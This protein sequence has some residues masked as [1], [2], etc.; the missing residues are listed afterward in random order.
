MNNACIHFYKLIRNFL[1]N[2]LTIFKN[3]NFK[4]TNF[5]FKY[6]NVCMFIIGFLIKSFFMNIF[7]VNIKDINTLFIS[8]AENIIDNSVEKVELS[9]N[10]EQDIINDGE[11]VSF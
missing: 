1:L 5:F 8:Y 7:L 9:S 4:F 10:L 3:L 2:K 6:F 11:K